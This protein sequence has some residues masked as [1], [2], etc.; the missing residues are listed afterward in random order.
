M[1]SGEIQEYMAQASALMGQGKYEKAIGYLEK[2]EISD[3]FNEEIY[4]RKGIS[5][6]N[7]EAYEE[8][9]QEF[10]KALKINKKMA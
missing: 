9:K 3:R 10:E 4:V 5:Y 1:S 8:A 6:A 2:A 7:L